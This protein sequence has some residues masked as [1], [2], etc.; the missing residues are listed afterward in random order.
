MGFRALVTLVLATH[1]AYL[2]YVVFGG[3]LAWRWRHA[4]WS[5]V[6]AVI[7]GVLVIGVPLTCPLTAA[8]NWA[9]VRAGEAKTDGFIDRY[10]EGVI[11]PPQYVNEARF[12]VALIILVSWWGVVRRWRRPAIDTRMGDIPNESA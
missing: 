1:F 6:A 8:E 2:A 11:Y 12:A 10:I 5:H 3:F 4:I 9:R 7:W